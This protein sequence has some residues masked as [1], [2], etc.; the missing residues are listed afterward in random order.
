MAMTRD[1]SVERGGGFVFPFRILTHHGPVDLSGR[2]FVFR[3]IW[4]GGFLRKSSASQ[5]TALVITDP[6]EGR[7][8]VTLTEEEIDLLPAGALATYSL[9]AAGAPPAIT[10]RIVVA[11]AAPRIVPPCPTK[12]SPPCRTPL[13]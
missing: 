12:R 10:G 2:T 9:G 8:E 5:L 6:A 13:S 4:P 7:L 11:G 1:L 3:V